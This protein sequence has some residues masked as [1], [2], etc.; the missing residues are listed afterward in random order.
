M[1]GRDPARRP[2]P[3]RACC[4]SAGGDAA[5]GARCTRDWRLRVGDSGAG[6]AGRRSGRRVASVTARSAEP[7]IGRADRRSA[8]LVCGRRRRFPR[9]ALISCRTVT[10]LRP[11]NGRYG[12]AVT[13]TGERELRADGSDRGRRDRAAR[14]PARGVDH[15][16]AR[17]RRAGGVAASRWTTRCGAL[18]DRARSRNCTATAKTSRT[19]RWCTI[20]GEDARDL[21]RCGVLAIRGRRAAG[22]RWSRSPTSVSYVRARFGA[23]HTKRA[24]GATRCTCRIASCRCC[25]KRS[26]TGSCSL[27][28]QE[29]RLRHGVR[30]AGCQRP[31]GN[32][33]LPLLHRGADVFARAADLHAGRRVHR[34]R[35]TAVSRA[36]WP[37]RSRALHRA[38]TGRC[39]PRA[40]IAARSTSTRRKEKLDP[41]KR[42][43]SRRIEPVVRNDA[44]R[45]IEEATISAN[46][47]AARF[48]EKHEATCADIA[49]L[50]GAD[51]GES[52]TCCGKR[53]RTRA[54]A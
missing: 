49:V 22:G 51:A 9:A 41:A 13:V 46:V 28:P 4:R 3:A 2:G 10:G 16:A 15:A 45:L 27:R 25:R 37:T 44:H 8:R 19:S 12:S 36:R 48:L 42:T 35:V 31:E 29:H 50:R 1:D 39:S 26:R 14:R 18:P 47:C 21:R 33:E 7:V 34:R 53:W 30:H 6:A 54:F 32:H 24:S 52:S 40:R 20:D 43:C 11:R 5:A 38:Y 23:R 17:A